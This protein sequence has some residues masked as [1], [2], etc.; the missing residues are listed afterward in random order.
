MTDFDD[1]NLSALDVIR[2]VFLARMTERRGHAEAAERWQ[3][4]ADRWLARQGDSAGRTG[5]A[6]DK[7]CSDQ[8]TKRCLG[9][10]PGGAG[11][12]Q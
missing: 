6:P 12:V 7:G 10:V 8:P 4:K 9:Q 11:G 1:H 5:I 3:A 2:C